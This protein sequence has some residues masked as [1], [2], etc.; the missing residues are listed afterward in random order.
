MVPRSGSQM[1]GQGQGMY[2]NLNGDN[3][4]GENVPAQVSGGKI[5][6]RWSKEFLSGKYQS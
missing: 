6:P 3:Y 2:M 5:S 1:G 4:S